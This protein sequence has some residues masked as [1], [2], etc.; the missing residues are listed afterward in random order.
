MSNYYAGKVRHNRRGIYL[1][2]WVNMIQDIENVNRTRKCRITEGFI[3]YY[4]VL[5]LYL[6]C[7][8]V[9]KQTKI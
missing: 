3:C 5:L 1:G 8:L 6:Q 7:R 2:N 4:T 9:S